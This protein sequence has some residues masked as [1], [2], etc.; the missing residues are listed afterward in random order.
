[1]AQ[2]VAP[3][4]I[5]GLRSLQQTKYVPNQLEPNDLLVTFRSAI[6]TDL[7]GNVFKLHYRYDRTTIRAKDHGV[8]S[9]DNTARQMKKLSHLPSQK[10]GWIMKKRIFI[11]VFFILMAWIAIERGLFQAQKLASTSQDT[12][13]S[14]TRSIIETGGEIRIVPVKPKGSEDVNESVG[15]PTG[16]GFSGSVGNSNKSCCSGAS[17]NFSEDCPNARRASSS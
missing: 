1:M 7:Y 8:I 11:V 15:P 13:A 4:P 2:S 5:T 9:N 16:A 12:K 10:I 3:G 14:A 17:F 6:P